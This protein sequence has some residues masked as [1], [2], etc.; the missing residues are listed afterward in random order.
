MKKIITCLFILLISSI[1]LTAQSN[2]T[3][4][5]LDASNL[6]YKIDKNIYGQFSEHLGNCI[7]GGIWVGKNSPIPNINGIRK[8]VIDAL[9]EIKV[10]VLRW[11]GGCFADEYHWK[12]GIGPTAERPKMI[13]T[14]WGGVTEDNS[15]GTHEFL[16]F[17]SLVG[18]QPY[19]TGNI[20]SGT[21]QELSQWIEYTNSDNVSP[22][23]ELRK[24]NGRNSSWGVKYWG[25]GNESWGCGGNMS[26]EYYANQVKR[27]G[28]FCKNYG[29]NKVF[30]IACG[31]SDSDYNWTEVVM[32]NAG[33]NFDGLSLHHYSFA[34]DKTAADFNEAG[35][36]DIMSKSLQI[37]EL[38]S[39]H[40][41]I[42]DKYDHYKRVALIVDEW[43]T[44]FKVEPETNPGFLFQQNT[45]RDAIAAA[46]NLN[47]FNNH[48]DRVRMANIAQ[49]VN[50]LQA[51]ILTKNNQMV[52]TPTYYVFDLFKVH[53]DAMLVPMK[54][55]SGIY[56]FKDGK[57]P[58]VNCSA[59][60]DADGKMH[61]SLCNINPNASE[62][63]SCDLL[64][65]N[66]NKSTA[67]ILTA[68]KMNE[69]NSFENPNV[70]VPK[71]FSDYKITS[72][73]LVVNMPPMSVIVLELSGDIEMS[74][75]VT[76]NNP[77]PGINFQYFEGSWVMLP[78]FDKLVPK[79]NGTVE[80]FVIPEKNSGTNFGVKYN[81]YI[82]LPKDGI[83]TFY[84]NSDDG[85][86]LLIDDKPI[87]NNDGLH[88]P[89]ENSGISVVKAGYHKIE[90]SFFQQGGGLALDVSI[91]G[92]GLPKQIIPNKIL[93]H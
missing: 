16:E 28:T 80:S 89:V 93:F 30:K 9:K 37:N 68:G 48:C 13:N 58:A 31:P 92:G 81:G 64:K 34:N 45:M 24:K 73:K 32:K 82:K 59:S 27:Y 91:E 62:K 78:D 36:F 42:M 26:P 83:Y 72:N 85:S 29:N 44:W 41:E 6:Q 17:C 20:G 88:A 87:I 10:P 71:S 53:Q 5:T 60:I 66:T 23:T 63:I 84:L 76:L 38:I 11:P 49:M 74:D 69:Y 61:V 19:F 52:L 79:A 55:N 67:K 22:M 40:S 2:E 70:L 15:F 35:W 86:V 12:D 65:F 50:V 46:C 54:I 77:K 43:G 39:K 56:S 51:M 4:I 90:V 47:I 75:V 3:Q 18:C 25:I 21:V 33:I 57:L 8:D 1:K 14:N 7:Y